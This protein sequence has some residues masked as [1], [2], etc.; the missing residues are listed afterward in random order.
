MGQS[1]TATGY[2]SSVYDVETPATVYWTADAVNAAGQITEAM[3]GNGI[4]TTRTYDAKTGL[5]ESIQSGAGNSTDIQ[6]LGYL[7]DSFGNLTAREDFIQDV[8]EQFTFDDLNRLT[9]ATVYDADDD[10]EREA[11]TYSYDAIGNIVNKSDVGA[12][13]YVYGTGNGAGAGDAGPHAVVS[14]GGDSYAYDDTGNMVSGAGR[15]LTWTS[16]NKPK[17][18][19]DAATTTTFVYGPERAR[20]RQTRVQGASTT[21]ITYVGGLFEQIAQTGAATKYLHYI[22]AGNARVAIYTTDD[23]PTPDTSLRYLHQDHLGSVDTITDE[24]GA[25]VERLSYDPFGKRRIA[26]GASAWEDAALPIAA[27]ETPRGF[28]DHEHL[29][30]FQLVHMN[31][32]VYDP[33][34]GRFLSADPFIRL[35]A[36]RRVEPFIRLARGGRAP[37]PGRRHADRSHDRKRDVRPTG[38]RYRR[39]KLQPGAAP[40]RHADPPC[41]RHPPRPGPPLLRPGGGTTPRRHLHPPARQY[42]GPQPLRLRRQQP[43]L[44]HRSL[45][46]L[47]RARRRLRRLGRL[48]RQ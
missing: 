14:A 18:I 28:T 11:K 23:A 8:Y 44:L 48:L 39:P 31:G 27:A 32:R 42:P 43:P 15:T 5:I 26:A 2:L 13:D 21:A 20:I 9:G 37:P 3:L 46:V 45:R 40:Q 25:V 29:D 41:G 4:G 33:V 1:Y 30:D 38:H 36:A 24:S 22:F 35:P 19:V 16:F 34:L 7:F 10:G 12:A 47:L 17:T 6:D